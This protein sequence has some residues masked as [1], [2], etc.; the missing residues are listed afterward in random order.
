MSYL[1]SLLAAS[2]N[3]PHFSCGNVMLDN[4]LHKQANQDIKRKLSACFIISD[5]DKEIK[6]Y[7]TLSSSSIQRS[8]LPE[9]VI[10]K[11][12][13]SYVDLPV[14]LLGRLAVDIKFKGQGIGKLLLLDAL[15][16]SY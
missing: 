6:G 11:L 4:Y 2:H 8:K 3:K 12:P 13:P 1:A 7:Y 10:K 9:S 15:R 5:D 16:R 14:T